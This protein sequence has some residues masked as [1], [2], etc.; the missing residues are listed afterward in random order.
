[1][2]YAS[3]KYTCQVPLTLEGW[4]NSCLK[5]LRFSGP[6]LISD[7]PPDII[8]YLKSRV[9]FLRFSSLRDREA[10]KDKLSRFQG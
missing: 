4:Y 5:L 9:G 10:L 6:A 2:D 1:M 3:S 8:H 7:P